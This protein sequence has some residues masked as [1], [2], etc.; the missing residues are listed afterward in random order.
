MCSGGR[1]TFVTG[2]LRSTLAIAAVLTAA[3]SGPS[4][5]VAQ[6]PV[7]ELDHVYVVVPP[8]AVG[9]IERL[10]QAGVIIDSSVDRHD[11]QGTA[12]VAA[13]FEN[14]YLELLWVDSSVAV[15]SLHQQDHADFVRARDW[16]QS[17]AS[18]FGVGLHFVSGA[19]TDLPVPVRLDS[20]A[21]LQP[22]TYYILLRQPEE[23]LAT[24]LFIM[25][26]A[27]AVTTWMA[28]YE[29]RRPDL[30]AHP[31]GVRRITRVVVRGPAPQ[32]PRAAALETRLVSFEEA[33][34]PH[35][36][37]EFDGGRRHATL[38]LRPA[39]PLVLVY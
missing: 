32:R 28:R 27:A 25:P 29:R 36:V 7:L 15:D 5:V 20:A 22:G 19:V 4:P 33:A 13:M 1:R 35:L 2:P 18:P 21:R 14:A 11:G 38:D 10:R 31:L 6:A 26:A 34:S 17:G 8:G 39:V 30:F 9:A 23:S 24:D 12:S 3:G 16:H 37:V